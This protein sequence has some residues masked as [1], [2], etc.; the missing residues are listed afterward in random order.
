MLKKLFAIFLSVVLIIG[1]MPQK[2]MAA[3]SLD[4][5]EAYILVFQIRLD[6]KPE[7][8]ELLG[9]FYAENVETG[10]RY[11]IEKIPGR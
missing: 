3:T 9:D 1:I 5:D 11:E 10:A 2:A 8:T 4:R 7:N 6:D